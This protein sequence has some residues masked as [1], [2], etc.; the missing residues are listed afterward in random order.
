M[1]VDKWLKLARLLKRR[2]IAQMACDQGRVFVNERTA[3]SSCDLKVGDTVHL[4]LGG[5]ALTVRVLDITKTTV[6]ASD[7]GNLYELIEEIRRPPEV[8]EWLPDQY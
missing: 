8:L 5:R 4:E 3:K 2:T 7:S 1:R 6:R